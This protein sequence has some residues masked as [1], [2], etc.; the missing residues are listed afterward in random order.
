MKIY[1][2]IAGSSDV[3]VTYDLNDETVREYF[4]SLYNFHSFAHFEF[5]S[6]ELIRVTD[7]NYVQLAKEGVI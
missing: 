7:D 4:S 3:M 6:A 1:Y 5:P 2:E